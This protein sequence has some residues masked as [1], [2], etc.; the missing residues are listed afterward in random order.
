M[1]YFLIKVVTIILNIIYFFIKLFRT[2]NKITFISRQ[3]NK[4]SLDF[5]LI[6]KEIKKHNKYRTIILCKKLEG[7]ENASFISLIKYGFHMFKQIYH[8]AT[9]K[10]VILDSYCIPI[11]ILKHKKS[12]KVIQIWHSVGTMKKFGYDIIDQEEGNSSK[13]TKIMKMHKNYDVILCAG[14]GYRHDLARQFGYPEDKIEIIPLPRLDLLYDK[15][16]IEKTKEKIFKKYTILKNKK[17]I[18]YVPTFRN[19]EKKLEIHINKLIK[20]IDYNKYNLIIKLHPLSK[21]NISDKRVI[22]PDDFNSMEMILVSDYVITDYSCILYEAGFINKPLYFDAFDYE[23]Y[24]KNRSLNLDYFKELPGVVTK[25]IE[26]IINSIE[27]DKY[28]YKKLKTFINKYIKYDSNSAKKIYN[29]I[30]NIVNNK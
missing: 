25:N 3:S 29:L 18:I 24:N 6:D 10:V 5:E 2:K 1:K 4:P 20:L 27:N 21:I 9:S 16:Y 11:S 15:K 22:I 30:E 17:N 7:K 14:E 28:D 13:M 26:E 19:D 12:L 23:E 8:I